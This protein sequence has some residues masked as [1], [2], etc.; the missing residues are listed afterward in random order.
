LWARQEHDKVVAVNAAENCA[1]LFFKEIAVNDAAGEER[2][3]VIP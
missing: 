2:N 3:S 1:R